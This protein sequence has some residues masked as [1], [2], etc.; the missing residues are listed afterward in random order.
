MLFNVHAIS[1]FLG[2]IVIFYMCICI[3]SGY[4]MCLFY[5]LIKFL[6]IHFYDFFLT[7]CWFL[8]FLVFC[9]FCF[10]LVLLTLLC[11]CSITKLN[12]CEKII[13][14]YILFFDLVYIFYFDNIKNRWSIFLIPSIF[15]F[16][17]YFIKSSSSQS[18]FLLYPIFSYTWLLIGFA[19][20]VYK[21]QYLSPLS[22]NSLEILY[23]K[24]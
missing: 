22:N 17:V 14:Y 15:D 7:C 18:L 10:C 12:I 5:L 23:I 20:S 21:T 1:L 19:S 11:F 16:N 9:F 6:S 24:L 8:Q 4:F 3:S 13:L 2:C